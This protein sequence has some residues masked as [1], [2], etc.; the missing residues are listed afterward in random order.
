M[1]SSDVRRRTRNIETVDE[2]YYRIVRSNKGREGVRE[3]RERR[4][5]ASNGSRY[6]FLVS[7]D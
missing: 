3:G 4:K 5:K 7:G 6:C 2:E 1:K